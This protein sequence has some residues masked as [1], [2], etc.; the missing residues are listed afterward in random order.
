MYTCK[1][2][3]KFICCIL[4]YLYKMRALTTTHENLILIKDFKRTF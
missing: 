1:T 3:I 2:F 4:V